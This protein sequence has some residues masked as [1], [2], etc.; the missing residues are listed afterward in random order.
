MD[1]LINEYADSN[2]D[3]FLQMIRDNSKVSSRYENKCLF[4]NVNL[5]NEPIKIHSSQLDK[6]CSYEKPDKIPSF[7]YLDSYGIKFKNYFEICINISHHEYTFMDESNEWRATPLKFKIGNNQFEIGPISNLMV[8]LTEP[9]YSDNNIGFYDFDR[10]ATIKLSL[11]DGLDYKEE[12]CKA[13]Y[14]LNSYYLKPIGFHATLMR[15]DSSDD[16]PLDILYENEV[17]DVFKKA[18]RKRN[19]KRKNFI[20]I[21]PLNLYNEAMGKHGEQRFMLLYRILEFF[22]SR[23]IKKKIVDMRYDTTISEEEILKAI[24]LKNEEQ[25]LS[26]LLKEV[27]TPSNKRRLSEFCNSNGL[28]D[29]SEFNKVCMSLYAYR[30]SLVHAKETEIERTSF[31]DPFE[32]K[33]HTNLWA[34][35]VDEI[36]RKCIKKYNE[37]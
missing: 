30:N 7:K 23:A 22:I 5:I 10:F 2:I 6:I 35:I 29:G 19:F 4:V 17:E 24:S 26:N 9:I 33:E 3:H 21:E 28:I 36:A 11:N 31:P 18:S 20:S 15:L 34:N 12:F 14:Y 32:D 1:E 13:L 27:L 25:Q 16:D 37:E 8:L